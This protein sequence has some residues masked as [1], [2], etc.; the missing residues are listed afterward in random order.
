MCGF[1][2]W[3][4]KIP[5]RREWQPTPACWPVESH[6]Q[7]SLVG[8]SPWGRRESDTTERLRT[9]AR[10]NKASMQTVLSM[11]LAWFSVLI[12]SNS[13]PFKFQ[14]FLSSGSLW[15]QPPLECPWGQRSQNIPFRS[16]TFHLKVFSGTQPKAAPL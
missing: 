9:H 3:V 12:H 16:R 8:Y 14:N 1:D 4:R 6:G 11:S 2:P 13:K 7:R 10:V 5:C 15:L